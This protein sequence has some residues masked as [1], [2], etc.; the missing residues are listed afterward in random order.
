MF[1][2]VA[3]E[4]FS[5]LTWITAS[6]SLSDISLSST[7]HNHIAGMRPERLS[8]EK[9]F[10]VTGLGLETLIFMVSNI[11]HTLDIPIRQGFFTFLIISGK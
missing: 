6:Y 1:L 5:I 4:A 8:P 3:V 2:L 7:L 10:L 9:G 11:F